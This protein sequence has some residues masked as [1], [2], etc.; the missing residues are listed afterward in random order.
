VSSVLGAVAAAAPIAA[1]VAQVVPTLARIADISDAVFEAVGAGQR[2]LPAVRY[3]FST[4]EGVAW[5]VA[6]T[7]MTERLDAIYQLD[8]DLMT[9]DVHADT[10]AML[11]QSCVF[12]IERDEQRRSVHGVVSRVDV[13]TVARGQLHVRVHVV[14]ALALLDQRV[15]SRAYQEMTVPE[16]LEV[17]GTVLGEYN[18][19]ARFELDQT[20]DT[21]DYCVQFRE[22][23]L[24]FHQRLMQEEGM[25]FFFDHSDDEAKEVLVVVDD[26]RSFPALAD[27]P[28]QFIEQ[29]E[30]FAEVESI[31][32]FQSQVS[33][34]PTGFLR[35]DFDH[36]TPKEPLEYEV[37][38]TDNLGVLRQVYEHEE[39]RFIHDDGEALV[40]RRLEQ[41]RMDAKILV[42]RS[43]VTGMTAGH[44]FE[45]E[46]H[47]R[48][49]LDGRYLVIEVAHFGDSSEVVL[50]QNG[51]KRDAD[52]FNTFRC[53]PADVPYRPA[54]IIP[55]PRIYGDLTGTVCGPDKSEV[56]TDEEGRIKVAMHW[57][58]EG[59]RDDTASCWIRVRHAWAGLGYGALVLPR[60]GM[61]VLVSFLD[62]N[63]DRPMV[64]GCVYNGDNTPP[65]DLPHDKTKSTFRTASSPGGEGFNELRIEDAA[66]SEEIYVHAQKDFNAKVLNACSWNVGA[67]R[68]V[69]VGGSNTETVT[70]NHTM[71]V[72]GKGGGSFSGAKITVA[73]DYTLD[74]DKTIQLTALDSITL[75]V[76][77]SMIHITPDD[78]TIVSG[79]NASAKLDNHLNL[80]S[81]DGSRV[82]LTE[83]AAMM[84]SKDA[85]VALT[86][87]AA[88]QAKGEARVH[89][90]ANAALKGKQTDCV[91][92][93]GAVLTLTANASLVGGTT[94]CAADG[95]GAALFEKAGV[96]IVGKKTTVA[97]EAEVNVTGA[98]I[99]IG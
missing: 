56:H 30:A 70:G 58:V 16:I 94:T 2:T 60:V 87:E 6:R 13:V 31:Q 40:K 81:A 20:Y 97:G 18:R 25:A 22:S 76:G 85:F 72:D 38:T 54:P 92:T 86:D 62:G 12:D 15:F 99:N 69:S 91:S 49:E 28:I 64:T 34:R 67:G 51:S 42:G 4:D 96:T 10:D 9:D 65:L 78:I 39:R 55:R 1:A 33:L 68:S 27:E 89:L 90:N 57:D 88:M 74:A 93:D 3:V 47:P 63:P 82:I 36:R 43:N 46:G 98:L 66:G 79:K 75:S 45:L 21:R 5:K 32:G 35:R 53:I 29:R 26:N 23:D 7:R 84:S 50:D 95:G 71:H 52:Y 41:L 48:A 37:E 19:T 17:L 83:H 44:V 73:G 11:G 14:P 80:Q 61:E 59:V 24:R 77:S 8:L